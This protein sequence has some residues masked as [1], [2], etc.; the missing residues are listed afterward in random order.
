[1][2]SDKLLAFCIPGDITR[3]TGGYRYDRE[4]LANLPACGII[5]E[6]IV[7][8]GAHPSASAADMETSLSQMAAEARKGWLLVDGLA[9]GAMPADRLGALTP[10]LIGLVHHP[11]GL[12]SGLP[13]DRASWLIANEKAV[14]GQ[15]RH[16]IVTSETTAKT[17][18][19]DFDVPSRKLTVAEPGVTGGIRAT[20]SGKSPAILA[21]GAI[22][23]RKAY[24]L[25]VEALSSCRDLDW[26]LRIVGEDGVQP[27]ETRRLK[28]TIAAH[29][30]ID[31]IMVTGPVSETDLA[32][33]YASAD[34]FAMSSLYEGYGMA[35]AEALAHG[36]PI[37]T[38]TGGAAAETVPDTAALKV[39]PG[40]LAALAMA[41]RRVLADATLRRR[42]GDAAWAAA[43]LLP[44]W[45]D[46]T[47]IIA[48]CVRQLEDGSFR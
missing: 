9:L 6:H 23:A 22:S 34:I 11:L 47:S 27:D 19:D 42:L 24:P 12:E 17:L 2:S 35:L 21:V 45:R 18:R 7:L 31:R 16:V 15:C 26:S 36:L 33:A 4:V 40:D 30:L 39:P 8:P 48:D 43:A 20:G 41:L 5:A 29:G 14:L 10:K 3:V 32:R 25:L 28:Q 37:V 13:E 1:V 46:T 38:S 44:T